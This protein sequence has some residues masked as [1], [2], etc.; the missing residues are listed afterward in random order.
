VTKSELRVRYAGITVAVLTRRARSGIWCRYTD[1]ARERWGS[2]APVLSCS[3]PL[4]D[5][6]TDATPFFAGLL[7]EAPNLAALASRAGVATSDVFGLLARYGRDVAG[8]LV[9]ESEDRPDLPE[10]AV[11]LS[12]EDLYSEVASL[13][14]RPLG[15][16][17]DSEL[18][19]PGLQDKMLLVE[20][21]DGSWARPTHGYPSTHILKLDNRLHRGVV[22]AE[23]ECLR[24]AA[25]AGLTAAS[26]E[27]VRIADADCLI[28]RRFDRRIDDSGH[29]E[30]IHQEDS[31]QALGRLAKYEV[32]N[33]AGGPELSEIAGLLVDY[34]K[35]PVGELYDLVRTATFNVLIGNAD[36]HGKNVA[37]LHDD[38][39]HIRLA[40][41]YDTVPTSLW[42]S[43]VKDSAMTIAGMVNLGRIRPEHIAAEAQRWPGFNA[44]AA[45]DTAREVCERVLDAV[46]SGLVN[47]DTAL[48]GFVMA[49][50]ERML[51]GD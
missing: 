16:H 33:G 40:P 3:L 48:P 43:L 8:A 27:L 19:I 31:C 35:D 49:Q 37:L 26:S 11:P 5:R 6:R 24:L 34:A 30:R 2:N 32:R 13:D 17:D 15:V 20:L 29:V 4:G 44:A 41:L 9:V 22:I 14:E 46:R 28:V 25:A 51:S 45:L 50:A 23:H 42:P 18:S 7:P 36:A 47:E 1:E 12:P 10:E 21:G 39:E 38:P